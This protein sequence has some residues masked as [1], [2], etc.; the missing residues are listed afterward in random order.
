MLKKIKPPSRSTRKLHLVIV[1][2]CINIYKKEGNVKRI[3]LL[4]YSCKFAFSS[5]QKVKSNHSRLLSLDSMTNRVLLTGGSREII[6]AY[7][8]GQIKQ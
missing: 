2:E 4:K 6:T 5:G 3:V 8:I 7:L 1:C